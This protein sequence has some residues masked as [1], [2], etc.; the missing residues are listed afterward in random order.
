MKKS[1]TLLLLGLCAAGLLSGFA[2]RRLTWQQVSLPA[3]HGTA[4]KPAKTPPAVA[5][6]NSTPPVNVAIPRV[7]ST[8][9]L[10]TLAAL[11]DGTLYRRLAHW[12]MDASEQDIAAYWESHRGKKR[13]N[14]IAELIFIHWTRLNPLEA[15]GAVAGSKDESYAWRAWACHDPQGSLAAAV[16]AGP[17]QV[18]NVAAGIGEFHPEW[19]RANLDRIP[20][21]ARADAL[22]KLAKWED[23][24]NPLETLEF[25]KKYGSGLDLGALKA[26]IRKDPFAAFDWL[27]ENP[28]TQGHQYDRNGNR[29]MPMDVLFTTMVEERPDELERLAARTPSGEL[30]RK[31]ESALFGNLLKADPEAAIQQ[32]AS[33]ESPRIAAE[34]FAAVGLGL[35]TTD[36]E[37]AMEIARRLFAIYPDALE[38]VDIIDY[39]NGSNH[40]STSIPGAQKLMD[41]LLA[42]DP[43]EV[44]EASVL[45][46]DQSSDVPARFYR[47]AH[48][49]ARH[50]PAAYSNWVNRQFDPNIRDSASGVMINQLQDKHLYAEAARWA[51][52]SEKTRAINLSNLF[53]TWKTENSDEALK[54]LESSGLSEAE[55][56]KLNAPPTAN[57]CMFQIEK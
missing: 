36:P 13:G 52:T 28:G 1:S 51:M 18:K 57:P 25:L 26:L 40:R 29:Y 16:A 19:L 49:W 17:E 15:I 2:A 21:S 39:P 53:R 35:V 32:A 47:L 7:R 10:E 30:K 12:L 42:H 43:A 45:P 46:A 48:Q 14:D 8:D 3:S 55:K 38:F 11:D 6:A 41:A 50:D 56:I 20:E 37:K 22:S 33:T 9:T 44:L 24:G 54:W 27:K 34:R 31:M 4:G 5:P 23:N